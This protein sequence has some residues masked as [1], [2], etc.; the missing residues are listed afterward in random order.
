MEG[1]VTIGKKKLFLKQQGNLVCWA[2]K[3]DAKVRLC[4]RRGRRD[5]WRQAVRATTRTEHT[6][7]MLSSAAWHWAAF[8]CFRLGM[9]LGSRSR[10]RVAGWR[11]G[12]MRRVVQLRFSRLSRLTR[13]QKNDGECAFKPGVT[14]EQVDG[15]FR[16]GPVRRT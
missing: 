1:T 16:F 10:L 4:R 2:A 9:Q 3:K 15:G 7:P 14:V 12:A 8:G 5:A 13:T 11:R 6:G